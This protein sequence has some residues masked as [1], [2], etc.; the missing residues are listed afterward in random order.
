MIDSKSTLSVVN[1]TT[2]PE[3]IRK[4]SA[5]AVA[6]P[7]RRMKDIIITKSGRLSITIE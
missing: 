1:R 2:R 7:I 3:S 4:A 6:S 5:V